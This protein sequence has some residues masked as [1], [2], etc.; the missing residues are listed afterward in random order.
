MTPE[1]TWKYLNNQLQKILSKSK[2]P[3]TKN[4]P[5]KSTNDRAIDKCIVLGSDFK[6]SPMMILTI[7]QLNQN[8]K[9]FFLNYYAVFLSG[10]LQ[11]DYDLYCIFLQVFLELLYFRP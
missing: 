1:S 10:I 9:Q 3:F 2:P 4:K 8:I 11:Y 7:H 6:I 5:K